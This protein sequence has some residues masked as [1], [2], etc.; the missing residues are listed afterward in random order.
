[1]RA[2]EATTADSKSAFEVASIRPSQFSVGCYSASPPG[3][4]HYVVTCVTLRELIALAWKV[5]PDNIRGADSSAL[6][7]TYDLSAV[8]PD[9]QP[10]TQE[11]IR[12][13]LRQLL[14]E[15]FHVTVHAGTRQISGYALVIAKGGPKLKAAKTASLQQ[16]HQAG[17]SFN[18]IMLPGYIR[19][20]AAD[21]NTIAALLS[22]QTDATVVDQTDISG[23]FDIDLHFSTPNDSQSEWPGF[24]VALEQQLGLKLLPQK[25]TIRTLVIDH[26]D[27]DP[28]PN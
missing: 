17:Q 20:R 12:P 7:E 26:A 9:G 8:V 19:G 21:L 11:S 2:Q 28:T 22:A 24:S 5:H 13:M 3:G 4:T 23:V 18:N 27:S 15:R 10:W 25:V 6:G 1:M 16:G 14:I